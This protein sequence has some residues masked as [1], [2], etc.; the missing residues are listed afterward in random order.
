MDLLN[1]QE[2][3]SLPERIYL[4][5]QILIGTHHKTG[6]VWLF[7]IF[8]KIA[9]LYGLKTHHSLSQKDPTSFDILLNDQSMFDFESI[10]R[11]YKGIHIIRD[12]RDIIISST[13]YHQKSNE[14]WL[15][16]PNIEF[17]GM[18]YQE[19]INSL[20]SLDEQILFE[21]E[22]SSNKTIF[23]I[24]KWDYNNENFFEIKYEQLIKNTSMSLFREIFHFLHFPQTI[25]PTSVDI[26]YDNSL[27]SGRISNT[28]HVRSGKVKQYKKYFKKIHKDKFQK[29]FGNALIKLGYEENHNWINDEVEN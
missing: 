18:T 26:A 16:I 21:M 9:D 12:P 15:H 3:G 8:Q 19:K 22:H 27:F 7:T 4:P 2:I 29:L 6:T 17:K 1:K 5:F 28:T 14:S 11:P 20:S 24:L 10:K 25:I 13:F 23:N